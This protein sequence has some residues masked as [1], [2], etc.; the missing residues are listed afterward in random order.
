MNGRHGHARRRFSFAHEYAHV[1][2]DR[3]GHGTVSR[4]TDQEDMSEVRANAFAA[5]FLMPE[6]GLRNYVARL[7]KGRESRSQTE[8]WGEQGAPVQVRARPAP[9]SQDIQMYDVVQIMHH[10]GASVPSVIFRLKN[11]GLLS[12]AEFDKLRDESESKKLDVV[13]RVLEIQ[14]IAEDRSAARNEFVH[15]FLGLGIEASRR[16]IITR[17]K[18]FELA[19]L[20]EAPTADLEAVLHDVGP[21]LRVTRSEAGLTIGT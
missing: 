4:T 21:D 8:V 14:P 7:G 9:A 10:F 1:L 18:L 16:E 12:K 5:A 20:L 13:A 11:L 15:R 3:D 19:G 17:A 2:L 6:S